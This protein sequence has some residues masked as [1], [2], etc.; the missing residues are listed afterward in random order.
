MTPE[1]K[2]LY[3][4]MT[5]AEE[6]QNAIN[7]AIQNLNLTQEQIQKVIAKQTQAS[8]SD[9]V[10]E[11]LKEG[12]ENMVETA[13]QLNQLNQSIQKNI[14]QLSWKF[15]ALCCSGIFSIV[16]AFVVVFMMIVP[17]LDEIQERR[18]D[19]KQLSEYPI[20]VRKTSDGKTVVRVMSKKSCYAFGDSKVYDWCEI[21][22]KKY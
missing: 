10:K 7:Q 1:E 15:I 17:S 8:V 9:A 11:G 13:K 20:Q 2:K 18:A 22:P 6:Q 12:S 3:A 14:K 16:M 5:I 21:D 4:L 19:L